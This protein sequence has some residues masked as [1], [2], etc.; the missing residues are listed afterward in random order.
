MREFTDSHRDRISAALKKGRFFNC[1]VCGSEFWRKPY[2]IKKGNSRFCSKGCYFKW[3]KG[4]NKIV[5]NPFDKSGENNPNW[6]GGIVPI[7]LKI[8]ASDEFKSW[9]KSVFE[10]DD[11]TCQDCGKRSKKG[12]TVI[13]HAH[14][15]RPFAKFP[16]LR[17]EIDNGQTLCKN[18]HYKKPKGAEIWLIT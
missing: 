2:E 4:K 18:C 17:F 5:K 6:K 13:L 10:R 3:Q 1:E 7:N 14:H 12:M 8:R 16:E 11:Y 9:R 15:I